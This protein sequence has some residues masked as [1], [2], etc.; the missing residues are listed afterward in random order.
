M[1]SRWP[2][3]HSTQLVQLG[4]TVSLVI[5]MLMVR[6]PARLNCLRAIQTVRFLLATVACCKKKKNRIRHLSFKITYNYDCRMVLNHVSNRHIFR[7]VSVSRHDFVGLIYTTQF[8]IKLWRKLVACDSRKQK[9]VPCKSPFRRLCNLHNS[10]NNYED[11]ILHSTEPQFTFTA[12]VAYHHENRTKGM[13]VPCLFFTYL[14]T[15]CVSKQ[16][17]ASIQMTCVHWVTLV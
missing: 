4:R 3:L 10:R 1:N 14:V 9:I 6:V 2:A 17:N 12:A 11:H 15:V 16:T 13:I 5:K 7:V 8:G